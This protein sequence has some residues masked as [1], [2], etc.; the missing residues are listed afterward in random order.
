[1]YKSSNEHYKERF[2]TKVYKLALDGGCGCPNRDGT[3][4][5]GGCIFCSESGSGE[6]AEKAC[7]S[8]SVQIER[9]K[10]RVEAKNKNGKYIAYF[11]SFSNTYA[12]IWH[13]SELYHQAIAPDDIVALSIAT[14][15][16]CLGDDVINLLSEI[17]EIKPVYVELGFQ[18]M[19]EKSIE[20][21]RRGY[22]N[23][24]YSDAVARLKSIGINVV[25]HLI[26]GLPDESEE[27][28]VRSTEY[29]VA[30]GS[31][32]LKFHLLYVIEGT[33][34]ADDYKKGKFKCLSM[35]EYASILKSCIEKVPYDVVIH[36]ITGDGAKKD[37]IAP[38]WSADK[39]KVLN[40]L[41]GVLG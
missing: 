35:E 1:M 3:I 12:P 9:A 10:A 38:L 32:G 24:V 5:Y 23:E 26:L 41:R 33:G 37:L 14:R 34:L 22:P 17:N 21:I 36:R 16:D 15:P 18:T 31:D 4:G 20:Y 11:Q 13:L 6:F 27:M 30:A 7:E 19:H 25:T 39:K 28:M 2:A 8:I 29:A 40:Y